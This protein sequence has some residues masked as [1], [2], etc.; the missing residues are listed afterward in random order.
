MNDN[1][2]LLTS[3]Y[4]SATKLQVSGSKDEIERENE[5]LDDRSLV[6]IATRSEDSDYEREDI[7][8]TR[9]LDDSL[10]FSYNS[11]TKGDSDNDDSKQIETILSPKVSSLL[12]SSEDALNNVMDWIEDGSLR[13]S[14]DEQDGLTSELK[15]LADAEQILRDELELSSISFGVQRSSDSP[16]EYSSDESIEEDKLIK[17]EIEEEE[18]NVNKD[19]EKAAEILESVK[20]KDQ[21]DETEKEML[22]GDA[23]ENITK[24]STS[25]NTNISDDIAEKKPYSLYDHAEAIGVQHSDDDLC[26][27]SCPLLDETDARNF[28]RSSF[29]TESLDD[30]HVAEIL[31]CA[32][33]YIKPMS[34]DALCRIYKGIGYVNQ[35][36]TVHDWEKNDVH[37]GH[38]ILP[39]RTVTI[40]LRPDAQLDTIMTS[41]YDSIVNA[42]G[43]ITNRGNGNIRA[44]LPGRF[45][46]NSS[47]VHFTN[48]STV[49]RDVEWIG[50]HIRLPPLIV[51]SQVC[52]KKRGVGV[53]RILLLRF[54]SIEED[55]VLDNVAPAVTL[56]KGNGEVDSFIAKNCIFRE[57]AALLQRMQLQATGGIRNQAFTVNKKTN[58]NGRVG[59]IL[60]LLRPLS[61]KGRTKETLP[62]GIHYQYNQT[63]SIESSFIGTH[64]RENLSEY[65]LT[66]FEESPSIYSKYKNAV[67]ALSRADWPFLQASWKFLSTCLVSLDQKCLAFSTLNCTKFGKFPLLPSIDENYVSQIREIIRTSM[68]ELLYKKVQQLEAPVCEAE[69]Q[70]KQLKNVLEPMAYAYDKTLPDLPAIT[71]INAYPLLFEDPEKT[72]PPWGE[73]VLKVLTAIGSENKELEENANKSPH[74][75]YAREAVM[76]VAD[77]FK[78]QLQVESDARFVQREQR[79][80]DRMKEINSYLVDAI[81]CVGGS[82]GLN[83]AAT[84]AAEKIHA[85]ADD[86]II[87]DEYNR[88]R[89]DRVKIL[90]IEDQVPLL[91]CG[92]IVKGSPCTCYVTKHQLLL[93]SKRSPLFEGKYFSI[94]QLN[95]INVFVK[96]GKK[97]ALK[98]IPSMIIL[99][100]STDGSEIC[101]FRPSTGAHLFQDFLNTVKQYAQNYY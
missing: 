13:N 73:S 40:E 75:N 1:D 54:Y 17:G 92:V 29:K 47:Y 3:L 59:K 100:S 90:P 66:S 57:S 21:D 41:V 65:L 20:V 61:R 99:K 87:M 24:F 74:F 28:L 25:V 32:R 44:L 96:T 34:M 84:K 36:M 12:K 80:L 43:R 27:P 53:Q 83:L 72:C 30:E 31:S 76:K 18:Q 77:A 9:D 8:H 48:C 26:Y 10:H 23:D 7:N 79:V 69:F 95:D 89:T 52:A 94:V 55:Q 68:I 37:S 86:C 101:S 46:H 98:V 51:D 16:V 39:V 97:T 4:D 45:I 78:A 81:E 35:R 19:M 14:N 93:A 22:F 70:M 50:D 63:D 58:N 38:E 71:P 42:K 11:P 62:H 15:R 33:E 49:K 60:N 88:E 67:S 5:V 2:V 82:Y 56:S 91:T 85:C 64:A 6:E